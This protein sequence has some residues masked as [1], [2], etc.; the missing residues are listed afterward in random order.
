MA[1]SY[2]IDSKLKELSP[3]IDE[4][5]EW[6]NRVMR[7]VFY[8]ER[9]GDPFDP[10]QSFSQWVVSASQDDFASKPTLERLRKIQGELYDMASDLMHDARTT[11]ARPDFKVYDEFTNLYDDLVYQLRR[12]EH[13][14][15]QADTGLDVATGLRSR[16]A[17]AVDLEKEMERRARRGKPFCLAIAQID[18]Y[19]Q[20]RAFVTEERH[21][22]ILAAVARLIKKCIRSF[23]DAYRSGE[24]EFIMCLKHSDVAGG[25]AANNRLR[26]FLEE[27]AIIIQDEKGRSFPLTMSSCVAEPLPGDSLDELLA[28]MRSD[29]TRF[30]S[31]APGSTTLEYFEQSPLSRYVQELDS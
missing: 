28:N 1:L 13:D 4:H 17:M 9:A 27:E 24:G 12:L 18:N 14:A 25:T 21:R 22:E 5:A 2:E 7:A 19:D 31:T 20:I 23:D 15:V 6:Y 3:I 26:R 30:H 8:P 29:L 16:K 10:P 11:G